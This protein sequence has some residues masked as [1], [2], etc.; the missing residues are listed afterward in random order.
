MIWRTEPV[1]IRGFEFRWY[2][3]IVSGFNEN[4]KALNLCF[5]IDRIDLYKIIRLRHCVIFE[6]LYIFRK[7]VV[8]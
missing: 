7:K 3:I 2:C 6:L 1:R 4:N 8:E 5:F